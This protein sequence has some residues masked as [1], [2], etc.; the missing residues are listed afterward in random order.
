MNVTKGA[1]D[2][3]P[4]ECDGWEQEDQSNQKPSWHLSE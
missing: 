1:L 4:D 2:S 3:R